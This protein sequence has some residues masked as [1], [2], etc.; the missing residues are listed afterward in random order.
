MTIATAS[1]NRK[2][3]KNVSNSPL[4][5]LRSNKKEIDLDNNEIEF[6][7]EST[8]N[9]S[10]VSMQIDESI[11]DSVLANEKWSQTEF[12]KKKDASTMTDE[13]MT[14]LYKTQ[15]REYFDKSEI[16]NLIC[17]FMESF[18]QFNSRH[19]RSFS[20]II[21]VLLRHLNISF[22]KVRTILNDLNLMNVQRCHLW[23]HTI[24][25]EGMQLVF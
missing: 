10:F 23:A 16:Y 9:K 6:Q 25:D 8:L 18:D 15:I 21:Y 11:E 5:S 17:V 20:T 4:Y 24:V 2:V 13:H 1:S 22:N 3:T 19:Y 12:I 7:V 14:R